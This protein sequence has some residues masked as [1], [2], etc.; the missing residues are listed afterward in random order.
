VNRTI[1]TTTTT[2]SRRRRHTIP[3]AVVAVMALV[4]AACGDDDDASSGTTGSSANAPADTTQSGTEAPTTV[5]SADTTAPTTAGSADTTAGSTAGSGEEVPLTDEYSMQIAENKEITVDTSEFAKEPP[6][7]VATIVQGPINGWGTIF[8]VTM[9]ERMEE[10]G[11][12]DMENRLYVPWDFDVA[13]QQKGIEDAIAQNV[14]AIMLTSLSRAGLAASVERATA[15][16]VPVILCMAGAET[17]QFTAEISAEMPRMGYE[18]AKAVADELGGE[19]K[20]VMI[21]GIAGVDAAEFWK[22]GAH[23]AFDEYPGIE[24]VAEQNGNWSTADSLEVM[25]AVLA[26]QSEIDAIW[27]GGFEMGVGVVDAFNE[28][29]RDVPFIGGTGITN[30]FLRIA[31]EDDLDFFAVQFPP[32]GSAECVDT[33]VAVL[34]GQP[35]QKFTSV[36]SV[37]PDVGPL[38][39]E[40]VDETYLPQFNDDFIGPELYP[41]AVYKEAGF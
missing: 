33:M 36:V 31:Q 2:R 5:G 39:P 32:A 16:G 28:A 6:Y 35:V 34:E 11:K 41:D 40:E 37:L 22:Q 14:D 30:G 3:I 19:G 29:G 21:H 7:R 12:F 20:V 15:A 13:N 23:A 9:N 1:T 8:D 24:I 4:V 18:S 17:D 38:G 25:R 10:T 26:Q 27:A